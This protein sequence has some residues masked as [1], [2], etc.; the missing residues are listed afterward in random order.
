MVFEIKQ[1][2]S[3]AGTLLATTNTNLE[4]GMVDGSGHTVI[5]LVGRFQH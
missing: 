1:N 4:A 5:Q 2:V 3:T